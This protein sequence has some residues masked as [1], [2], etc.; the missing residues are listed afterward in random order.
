MEPRTSEGSI[1]VTGG[2]G[3]VGSHF[4]RAACDAGRRVVVVDDLSGGP[5]APLPR[6]AAF[7]RGD[8]ADRALIARVCQLHE[9]TAVAHF[10]GKIQVG[11]S[12]RIPELYFDVNLTRSLGLLD[13][14]RD[15]GVRTFLFSSTA[16]VYGV[17]DR[18]P[19]GEDSCLAP[20]N[21]YGAS[22]LGIEHALA[23]YEVAHGLRWAALRYFNAAGAHP[24]GS[25]CECHEPETHLI[26]L[27]IDATLGRRPPLAIYGDDYP[28]ADGTC[29][30][31]YIH[32]IDLAAAHLA[33][34]DVLEAGRSV[35][36][37]NLGSGAG[38]SVRE[39]VT[40]T[41][42]VMGRVV[43]YVMAARRPGDPAILLADP[44]RAGT[45]LGWRAQR[46]ALPILVEDALRARVGAASR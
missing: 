37:A 7:V 31:D 42:A 15:A 4:V 27:V 18:T 11:E 1:L 41:E 16:A 32:V 12:V 13:T 6:A 26:P 45:V 25:L 19:I 39:V 36:A 21:P 2:K 38:Y 5:G 17:P 43:P 33:A 30:R 35:G 3:F 29:I 40:T 28:T 22:K 34:L 23:A 14:V 24:D 9:V 44:A 8:I 10:A 20:I 46:S